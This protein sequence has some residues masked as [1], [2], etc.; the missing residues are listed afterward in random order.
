IYEGDNLGPFEQVSGIKMRLARSNFSIAQLGNALFVIGGLHGNLPETS[1]EAIQMFGDGF[2]SEFQDAGQLS[3]P[4]AR[5]VSVIVG[6]D[7]Y[8]IGGA[9]SS[10]TL[11]SVERAK[12]AMQT[13]LSF[14][15]A[16]GFDLGEAKQDAALAVVGNYVYV[17]GGFRYVSGSPTPAI[18]VDHASIVEE[19]KL[20]AFATLSGTE[21]QIA[22][23]QHTSMMIG[24]KLYVVGGIGPSGTA[25]GQIEVSEVRED[26][27]I[28]PF[29]VNP[30]GLSMPRYGHQMFTL[31]NKLY[32]VGGTDSTGTPIPTVE[33]AEIFADGVVGAFSTIGTQL[34]TARERFSILGG[35]F[36]A[37]FLG[38]NTAGGATAS[39]EYLFYTT[40]LNG[41]Q[42]YSGGVVDARSGSAAIMLRNYA[43]VLGGVD[44]TTYR[45]VVRAGLDAATNGLATIFTAYVNGLATP[46]EGHSLVYVGNTLYVVGGKTGNG[47]TPSIETTKVGPTSEL[48]PFTTSTTTMLQTP[49]TNHTTVT[50][51]NYVYVI[52][53]TVGS[54]STK[55]IEVS[56]IR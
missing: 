56:T 36:N 8:V 6:D 51:G 29:S 19:G 21:L 14:S 39:V 15:P 40:Q 5:H 23:S 53:G 28:G 50:I 2:I 30:N 49:R 3:E 52:G 48:S 37:Y 35:G 9:N 18:F 42:S 33:V 47:N 17:I 12:I 27:T 4:R 26:G 34:Q 44:G 31:N 22:R 13:S 46:R 41:P 45:G 20:D 25:V 7:V 54:S 55:S 11:A 32:V 1:I 24:N 43:Y 16:S 38:G 10:G